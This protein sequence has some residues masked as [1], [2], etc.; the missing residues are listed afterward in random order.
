MSFAASYLLEHNSNSISPLMLYVH[1]VL[2]ITNTS[3]VHIELLETMGVMEYKLMKVFHVKGMWEDF[4]E[5][6]ENNKYG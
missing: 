4:L 5:Y 3:V 6:R 1:I 2:R